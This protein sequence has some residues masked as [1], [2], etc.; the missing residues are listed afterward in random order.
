MELIYL[1]IEKFNDFICQQGLPLSNNFEIN[2][3][4]KKL[5]VRKKRNLLK[6]FYGKKITNLSVFVGKNG[7]GKTTVL[8]ILGMTRTD[9]LNVSISGKHVKD[10]YLLL[11]HIGVDNNGNDLFGIEVTSENVLQNI[12]TNYSH[13]NDD[14]NYDRSKTSIGK[15][16]RYE[17]DTFV[18]IE[19]H[20][21]DYKINHEKLCDMIKFSYIGEAYRYSPRNKQ[22]GNNYAWNGGYIAGRNLLT[23]PSVYQKYLTLIQCMNKKIEGFDCDKAIIRFD[24][25]IDYQYRISKEDFVSYKEMWC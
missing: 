5:I 9:R 21:F 1:Y 3:Q 15:I 20:F 7:S 24:D 10:D 16:Y 23:Q 8:D 19:K 22:F 17:N 13:E 18:S 12:I 6:N 4:D 2:M 14:E 25:E 11:Y